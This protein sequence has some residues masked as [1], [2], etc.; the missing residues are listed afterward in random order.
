MTLPK[1]FGSGGGASS[2]DVSKM[3]GRRIENYIGI[4]TG[5]FVALW[6]GTWG[7]VAVAVT[8]YPWA[9]PPPSA[10]F[11][12]TVLTII[13]SIGYMFCVKVATEGTD[14]AKTYNGLIAGVIGGLAVAT[15]V[16]DSVFFG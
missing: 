16:T 3:I 9:Y 12:L 4:I 10:H 8:Y 15:I 1:G 7:G 11:A 13:E 5:A 6:L 2:S 14:K